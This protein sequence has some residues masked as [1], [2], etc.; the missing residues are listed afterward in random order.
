MRRREAVG[1]LLLQS[2]QKVISTRI[3]AV[4]VG[5]EEGTDVRDSRKTESAADWVLSGR[6][7]QGEQGAFD[8][9]GREDSNAINDNRWHCLERKDDEL[10]FTQ[11]D[12]ATHLFLP[13][14]WI[15]LYQENSWK[16]WG[17]SQGPAAAARHF[18][19]QG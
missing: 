17:T 15:D 14:V 3:R 4:A 19:G 2:K 6:G 1:R 11:Q 18:N 12:V 5:A 9:G 7:R 13:A 8:P 16:W 10:C